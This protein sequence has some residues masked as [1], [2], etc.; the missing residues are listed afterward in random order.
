MQKTLSEGMIN[1]FIALGYGRV[2]GSNTSKRNPSFHSAP[3]SVLALNL[4]PEDM[5]VVDLVSR[6]SAS[7]HSESQ[8]SSLHAL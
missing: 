8:L 3:L 6:A 7:V 4:V 5:K 1:S 2:R